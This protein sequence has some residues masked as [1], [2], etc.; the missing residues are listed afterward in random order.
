[1]PATIPWHSVKEVV[2]HN[3]TACKAGNTMDPAYRRGG[4]G[5]K[6]LCDECQRLSD[7]G[8]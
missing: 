3:N 6:P 8:K 5:G 2:H 4:T 1:M 7:E